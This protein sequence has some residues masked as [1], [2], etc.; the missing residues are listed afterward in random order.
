MGFSVFLLL[1]LGFYSYVVCLLRPMRR[2][3][4]VTEQNRFLATPAP[5]SAVTPA[6]ST[7]PSE[8]TPSPEPRGDTSASPSPVADDGGVWG[9]VFI[10]L[11]AALVAMLLVAFLIIIAG[12]RRTHDENEESEPDF[13]VQGA[14]AVPGP[15]E[16]P[17][18]VDTA[19]RP[20]QS[21]A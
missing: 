16:Y 5:G 13:V 14:T 6:P 11:G 20:P 3:E 18:D 10:P 7:P 17:V 2:D 15:V 9:W 21:N 4:L 8:I 12:K 1:S 19:G